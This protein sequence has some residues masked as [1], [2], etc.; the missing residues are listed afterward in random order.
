VY[1]THRDGPGLPRSE[2]RRAPAGGHR[3]RN[4]AVMMPSGE[5]AAPSAARPVCGVCTSRAVGRT[6]GHRFEVECRTRGREQQRV[7]DTHSSGGAGPVDNTAARRPPRVASDDLEVRGIRPMRAAESSRLRRTDRSN[8]SAPPA[9][10]E[11]TVTSICAPLPA[12]QQPECDHASAST[13]C[14]RGGPHRGRRGSLRVR[15]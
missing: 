3:A 12:A 2:T 7:G 4:T 14:F 11:T 9:D 1:L 5:I 15:T 10:G 13:D 6:T 8:W